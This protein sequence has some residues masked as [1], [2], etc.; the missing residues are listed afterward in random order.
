MATNPADDEW[1]DVLKADG[2]PA[3]QHRRRA[4]C[5]REGL[6]HRAAHVWVARKPTG[7]IL[8]QRRAYD[9]DTWPGLLDISAGTPLP[10]SVLDTAARE[11]GSLDA[12]LRE[13][14]EEIGIA[15]PRERLVPLFSFTQDA[16]LNEGT[17]LNREHVDVFLLAC[18]EGEVDAS[19]LRLQ[20]EEVAEVRWVSREQYRDAQRRRDSDYVPG[21]PVVV[22]RL[23]HEL[24]KVF[25]PA[26][27]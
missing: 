20:K 9:K 16:V 1:F 27:N 3:G 8:L 7:D 5:H 19:Q 11:S 18:D 15:V 14:E 26:A 23:L 12:A 2:S 24:E 17:F 10:P 4:S 6:W 13:L 22:R 21:D 25:G